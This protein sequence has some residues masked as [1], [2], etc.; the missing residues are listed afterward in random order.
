MFLY[1]ILV[2][3]STKQELPKYDKISFKINLTDNVPQF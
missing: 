2:G 3:G 1:N